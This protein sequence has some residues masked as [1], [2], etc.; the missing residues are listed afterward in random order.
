MDSLFFRVEM[1]VYNDTNNLTYLKEE[2][3]MMNLLNI[4]NDPWFCIG[5]ALII[6]MAILGVAVIYIVFIDMPRFIKEEI[7]KYKEK[8]EEERAYFIWYCRRYCDW[9]KEKKEA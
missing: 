2:I 9:Y 1:L 4:L 8:K 3:I 5:V 6:L 7:K